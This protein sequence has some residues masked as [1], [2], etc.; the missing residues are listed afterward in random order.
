MAE[1]QHTYKY[2][3]PALTTDN[4]IF[5]FDGN[6]LYVLLI[7]RGKEPFKGMWAFPGGFVN[8]DETV[9]QAAEREL[10]EETGLTGVILEQ[11]HTFSDPDRDPR[12]RTVSV[13]FYGLHHGNL[14]VA[15]GDDA[16][17][18]KWFPVDQ[19]PDLAFDHQDIMQAAFIRLHQKISYTPLRFEQFS[20]A[21]LKMIKDILSSSIKQ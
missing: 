14:Y 3:R 7:Q 18:A 8:M 19:L 1:N 13:V 2:P 21:G 5:R 12:H 16:A 10:E 6:N 11:L 9:E 4:V 20:V 17:H 15:G